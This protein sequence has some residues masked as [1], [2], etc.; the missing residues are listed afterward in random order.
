MVA[1]AGGV[2]APSAPA[3]VSMGVVIGTS[4]AVADAVGVFVF[5]WGSVVIRVA[6]C[7][8]LYC[9]RGATSALIYIDSR[10][11]TFRWNCLY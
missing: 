1:V 8:V 11:G 5:V 7:V 9:R 4:S 3:F 2:S 10:W 6:G